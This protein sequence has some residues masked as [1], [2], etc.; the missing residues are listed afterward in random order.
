M[1]IVAFLVWSSNVETC[2]ARRGR[3]WRQTTTSSASL[4]KKKEK[5]HGS[6]H[7]HNNGSKSKP[8]HSSPPSMPTNPPRKGY[9]DV[10]SSTIFDVRS[11]GATGD[12][13]TDDTKVNSQFSP[14]MTLA[15]KFQAN[16]H[17]SSLSIELYL[18]VE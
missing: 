17:V 5:S 15:R 1:F 7:H 3:H 6:N 12:G 2:Y 13:K 8:K 14:A 18:L 4:Y 16:F 9:D 11:F 10:P